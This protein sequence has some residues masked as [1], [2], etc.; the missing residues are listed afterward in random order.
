MGLNCP[1]YWFQEWWGKLDSNLAQCWKAFCDMTPISFLN[2]RSRKTS[3]LFFNPIHLN[4]KCQMW[5]HVRGTV[6]TPGGGE[7]KTPSLAPYFPQWKRRR[8]KSGPRQWAE[9]ST[10]AAKTVQVL[11]PLWNAFSAISISLKVPCGWYCQ[12]TPAP[13]AGRSCP[14]RWQA[15]RAARVRH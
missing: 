14:H 7:P 10:E 11:G 12:M 1:P 8:I 3:G 4:E 2:Y 9:L 15:Q 6:W 5:R 13:P